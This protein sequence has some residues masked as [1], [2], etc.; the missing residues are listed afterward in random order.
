[1]KAMI[2]AAG[3]GRRLGKITESIPKA[4]VDINGKSALQNAVE[5]CTSSGFDDIIINVHHLADMVEAEVQKLRDIGFRLSVSDERSKLLETGGGLFKAKDFF[6]KNPFLL[7]NADIIT[8][9][10][11]SA[12]YEFHRK[13]KGLATLA[14]RNRMADRHFLINSTGLVKG[15][16]NKATGEKRVAADNNE[17]LTEIAFSGIHIIDPVIFDSMSEGAY[18]MT[19]LYLTLV[20]SHNICTYRYD[21][22]YW[23]DIGTPES[24]ESI[25]ELLASC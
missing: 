10:D 19:D 13:M 5:K 2:L 6:D 15:W 3:M 16:S 18:S 4:L 24:L 17:Q 21:G 25:R 1:M 9:I 8:D 22:G 23:G 14:V 7:Y 12:M 11:L 20:N